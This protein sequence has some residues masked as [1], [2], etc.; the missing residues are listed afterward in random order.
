MVMM[1][2]H[3][4]LGMS[5]EMMNSFAATPRVR[6]PMTLVNLHNHSSGANAK[7]PRPPRAPRA[8]DGTKIKLTPMGSH[9][10]GFR[11]SSWITPRRRTGRTTSLSR[12]PRTA[13]RTSR[14]MLLCVVASSPPSACR[15]PS[16][17][18]WPRG[19]LRI[20]S[21]KSVLTLRSIT[22]LVPPRDFPRASISPAPARHDA[23]ARTRGATLCSCECQG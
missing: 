11:S 17:S 18:A 9:S 6:E 13:T 15:S 5:I 21:F 4:Y 3:Q 10:G 16:F 20:L 2:M 22:P 8:V 1:M 19:C 7:R 23:C 12:T 14:R